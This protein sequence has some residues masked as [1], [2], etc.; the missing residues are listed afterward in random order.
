MQH[1]YIH[2]YLSLLLY[3]DISMAFH[4]ISQQ[5]SSFT[6]Q[7]DR[8]EGEGWAFLY[9]SDG[10]GLRRLQ[11]YVRQAAT[12]ASEVSESFTKVSAR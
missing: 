2:I 1:I 7:M 3:I 10:S 12:Q 8:T 11:D 4:G 5:T 6:L 9:L